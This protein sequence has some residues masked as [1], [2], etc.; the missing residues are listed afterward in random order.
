MLKRGEVT[1]L[2]EWFRALPEEVVQANPRLCEAYSWPLILTDQI[3]AAESY[4]ACA[5]QSL[6]QQGQ[7][8]S[9]LAQIAVARAHIARGR[10]DGPRVIELSARALELL[11]Q[12]S[13][14]ERS[15]TAMNLGI[16][17]WHSGRLLEAEQALEEARRAAR[18]SGNDYVRYTALVFLSR[19]QQARGKLRRAASAY[20]EIVAQGGHMPIVAL[21]HYD[22]CKLHYE[23]NDLAAASSH[24]RQGIELSRRSA[25]PEFEVRGH[26]LLARVEQAQGQAAAAQASLQ[27]AGQLIE[28]PDLTP[29]ARLHYLTQQISSTWRKGIWIGRWR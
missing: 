14:S 28:R 15:I 9:L 18:G 6:E 4:L 13:L 21:A 20:R 8:S 2:L 11:P 5:E 23:W 1:T 22:L 25:S 29:V 27:A 12:E 10:G 7:D 17:Q 26:A 3:E 19:V 16:A 24:A